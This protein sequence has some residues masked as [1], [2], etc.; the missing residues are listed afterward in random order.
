MIY[1]TAAKGLIDELFLK[2]K[3][4][5]FHIQ[6]AKGHLGSSHEISLLEY[7]GT[8]AREIHLD[9]LILK[10][11]ASELEG[12]RKTC[13]LGNIEIIIVHFKF[14]PLKINHGIQKINVMISTLL[15]LT[16]V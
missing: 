1:T 2:V 15:I 8:H 10:A 4:G 9:I 13:F 7:F 11:N 12:N 14:S 3:G 6:I 16:I 5:L